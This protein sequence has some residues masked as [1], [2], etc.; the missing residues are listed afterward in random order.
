M[1]TATIKVSHDLEYKHW[2]NEIDFYNSELVNMQH[3][4]AD[5]TPTFYKKYFAENVSHFQNRFI[6]LM[7]VIEVLRHDIKQQ[8]SDIKKL[9]AYPTPKLR[10]KAS[11]MH[12]RLR[13][14]V[15]IFFDLFLELKRDFSDFLA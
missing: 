3:Q 12:L 11:R 5:F 4:L 10:D 2:L 8:K 7:E 6:Y 15:A 13:N 9:Q 1:A 14:D